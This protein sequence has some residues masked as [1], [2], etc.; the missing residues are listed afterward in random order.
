MPRSA[1]RPVA[2]PTKPPSRAR[3]VLRSG[4]RAVVRCLAWFAT[5]VL[6]RS[7]LGA[8]LKRG[9]Q[10]WHRPSGPSVKL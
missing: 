9:D 3:Q 10:N 7:T 6:S 8:A 1:S 5:P 2:S 4:T